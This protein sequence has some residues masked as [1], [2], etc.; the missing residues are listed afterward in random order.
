MKLLLKYL[1][2]LLIG[3][4]LFSCQNNNPQEKLL[5]QAQ[6]SLIK[7]R[8]DSSALEAGDFTKMISVTYL[9]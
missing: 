3:I 2:S 4:L 1:F 5:T 9:Q 8:P 7:S 6:D